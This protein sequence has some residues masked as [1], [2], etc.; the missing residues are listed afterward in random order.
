MWAV[1]CGIRRCEQETPWDQLKNPPEP[2]RFQAVG[3]GE[4]SVVATMTFVP[5]ALA[6]SGSLYRGIFVEKVIRPSVRFMLASSDVKVTRT[7]LV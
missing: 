4:V 2:V 1:L 6:T 7:V 3:K 5:A